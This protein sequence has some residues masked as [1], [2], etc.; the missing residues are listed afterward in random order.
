MNRWIKLATF[1][2]VAAIVAGLSGCAG[3]RSSPTR[4]ASAGSKGVA[5]S[6]ASNAAARR[7]LRLRQANLKTVAGVK[8]YLRAIGVNPTGVVIQRGAHSYAGPSCPGAGWSCA[9]TAHPV[10]QVA[11]AGGR[12]T[13]LCTTGSCAVV[14]ATRSATATKTTR[15][16]T[17]AAAMNKATCIKTT[18][19]TQ[20]CSINQTN[21]TADN[22]A[23]VVENVP[24]TTGLTQTVSATAQITQRA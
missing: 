1:L 21:A 24:K 9:S 23:I 2:A 22:Q 18:G 20:S 16:L 6:A 7:G 8:R 3:A 17:A 15:S 13:F 11:A 5:H 10:V 14:Q 19:A 12:N 4:A